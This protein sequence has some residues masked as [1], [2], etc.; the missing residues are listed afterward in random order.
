VAANVVLHAFMSRG[1]IDSKPSWRQNFLVDETERHEIIV[2]VVDRLA[3]R[4]PEAPRALI[5]GVVAEEYNALDAGR[6]RTYIPTLVEHEARNR[7]HREFAS[8]A[9]EA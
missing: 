7:L 1:S 9:M 6:I 8:P 3:A 4:F 2:K 5:A